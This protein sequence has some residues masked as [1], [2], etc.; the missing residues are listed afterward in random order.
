VTFFFEAAASS[1]CRLRLAS[2]WGGR[3]G[4]AADGM[5][6]VVAKKYFVYVHGRRFERPHVVDGR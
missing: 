3:S 4:P 6:C 5:I 2:R 1:C